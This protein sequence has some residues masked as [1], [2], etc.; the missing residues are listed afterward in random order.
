MDSCE[1]FIQVCGL[2]QRVN[3]LG[4]DLPLRL[5]PEKQRGEL[6]GVDRRAYLRN[7][8][9]WHRVVA[10]DALR[11]CHAASENYPPSLNAFACRSVLADGG[12]ISFYDMRFQFPCAGML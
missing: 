9:L 11:T 1:Q 2:I 8:R 4:D 7:G 12:T 3:N 10:R 6:L 5:H